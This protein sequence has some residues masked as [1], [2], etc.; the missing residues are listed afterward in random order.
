MV[1]CWT[2][3]ADS[4]LGGMCLQVWDRCAKFCRLRNLERADVFFHVMLREGMRMQTEISF[5]PQKRQTEVSV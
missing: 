3:D 1:L 5:F 4:I 2:L